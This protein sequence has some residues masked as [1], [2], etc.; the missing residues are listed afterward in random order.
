[1]TDTN[2]NATAEALAGDGNEDAFNELVSA[3]YSDITSMAGTI[4]AAC[5]ADAETDAMD[6]QGESQYLVEYPTS[7]FLG[8]MC[9]AGKKRVEETM[10]GLSRLANL[11]SAKQSRSRGTEVE[12]VEIEKLIRSIEQREQQLEVAQAMRL[13]ADDAYVAMTG[14]HYG[15]IEPNGKADQTA[16]GVRANALVAKYVKPE[17]QRAP[18]TDGSSRPQK[19]SDRGQDFV[20]GA[21]GQY[22][23]VA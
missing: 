3:L 15:V 23:R 17:D 12:S 19:Y 7:R 22:H 2:R 1:M 5:T 6:Y 9:W 21:D 20:L 14:R 18:S 8:T 4:E 13:A 16:T 11:L 10:D